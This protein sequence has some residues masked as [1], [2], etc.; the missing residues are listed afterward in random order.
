M[1][2]DHPPGL[3]KAI[4]DALARLA[5][6]HRVA[7]LIA[8]LEQHLQ[9]LDP[10]AELPQ[11][12]E[13]DPDRLPNIDWDEGVDEFRTRTMEELWSFL[14]VGDCLPFFNTWLDT[15]NGRHFSDNKTL[16][17]E[18]KASGSRL[19]PRWHQLV[20]IAKMLTNCFQGRPVLLMDDVRIGKTL[21]VVGLIALLAYYREY[22]L[23]HGQF[24]GQIGESSLDLHRFRTA[25][26]LVGQNGW[27]WPVDSVDGNIP[28]CTFIVVVPTS[29]VLQ[30]SD[31][32]H[33]YLEPQTFD[34]LPYTGTLAKRPSW[35]STVFSAC[36][37]GLS[38]RIVIATTSVQYRLT[39]SIRFIYV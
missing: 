26:P 22:F 36:N 4:R 32:C 20:G 19:E 9:L 27:K 2:P 33:R 3:P 34:L 38:R 14:G 28:D 24:P 5:N 11:F 6:E 30:F 1:H 29:L 17:D 10:E 7:E 15:L 18:I 35:W 25:H 16:A 13:Y 39:H 8:Q 23:K 31:E 12:P 37:H 21:Q